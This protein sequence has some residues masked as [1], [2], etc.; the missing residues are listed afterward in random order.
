MTSIISIIVELLLYKIEK[1]LFKIKKIK[2]IE[3]HKIM[4]NIK[5]NFIKSFDKFLFLII[6]GN[7]IAVTIADMIALI[8]KVP[9]NAI[10]ICKKKL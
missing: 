7:M 10:F 8:I 6:I 9:L 2:D 4:E 1:K 3:V 5:I